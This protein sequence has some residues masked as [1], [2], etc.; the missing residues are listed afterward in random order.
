MS[1][2]TKIKKTDQILHQN[3]INAAL[4][5]LNNSEN[6][7]IC[8]TARSFG[9][10]ETSLRRAVKNNG[11]L[12]R[13]GRTTVLSEHEETQ[14]VGYCKN[15]QQLGFGL[16]KS[17][18]N[19][20][21]MEIVRSDNRNHPFAEKGPGQ[22]WWERFMK[23]HPD[24]SFRIPQALTEARAQRANATIVKDHF[25]KLGQ[26]IKEHSLT[27]DRIWNM[28]ETGFSLS[29]KVQKVLAAKGARQVHK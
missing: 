24:L 3:A 11:P 22:A 12:K 18:V 1:N 29:P 10:S 7:N 4:R 15:M 25:N 6:P 20:C 26:V 9:V 2:K 14:L 13:P 16:T 8:G 23:D 5:A 28:D 27:A 21:V 17:G 19:H